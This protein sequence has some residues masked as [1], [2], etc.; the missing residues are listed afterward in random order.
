MISGKERVLKVVER[1]SF[2]F[3]LR[4]R[5]VEE[6]V[7]FVEGRVGSFGLAGALAGGAQTPSLS[8]DLVQT[9]EDPRTHPR[10]Q[11]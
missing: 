2:R 10:Q 9:P 4:W 8:I 3:Q 7:V 11:K 1:S 6:G 5:G